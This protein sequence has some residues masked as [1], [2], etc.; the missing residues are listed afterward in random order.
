[1]KIRPVLALKAWVVCLQNRA[2]YGKT[3]SFCFFRT[4]SV[5]FLTTFRSIDV[6]YDVSSG[7]NPLFYRLSFLLIVPPLT[8]IPAIHKASWTIQPNDSLTQPNGSSCASTHQHGDTHLSMEGREGW[9]L[10]LPGLPPPSPLALSPFHWPS[11]TSPSKQI[12][13]CATQI[14]FHK[15]QQSTQWVVGLS[16]PSACTNLP[17]PSARPFRHWPEK[18]MEKSW[19]NP[20]FGWSVFMVNSKW[21]HQRLQIGLHLA[22]LGVRDHLSGHPSIDQCTWCHAW[23]LKHW[24]MA[25]GSTFLPYPFFKG[26]ACAEVCLCFPFIWCELQK[27][28]HHKR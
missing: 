16:A 2:H 20:P 28:P 27:T 22:T 23:M 12:E 7:A 8:N 10:K 3:S 4:P 18:T 15:N 5:F 17:Y 1:M 24:N 9:G 19:F 26:L 21:T 13:I 11:Y 14:N 25:H 6:S